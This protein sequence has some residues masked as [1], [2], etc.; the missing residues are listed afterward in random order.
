MQQSSLGLREAGAT[1]DHILGRR[2]GWSSRAQVSEAPWGQILIVPFTEHRECWCILGQATVSRTSCC[3][4]Y[5]MC[6]KMLALAMC[7]SQHLTDHL[8]QGFLLVLQTQ[9]SRTEFIVFPP[10]PVF[11]LCLRW[12]KTPLFVHAI[13]Q[14]RK[15]R[16][17]LECSLFP[18]WPSWVTAYWGFII[19]L[20][21]SVPCHWPSLELHAIYFRIV[22]L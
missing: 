9:W 19:R 4:P 16:A 13:A 20:V 8:S 11:F 22:E 10:N 5:H 14:A 17:V 2:K 6:T 3:H 1:S 7:Y 18:R 21:F 15:L 12:F